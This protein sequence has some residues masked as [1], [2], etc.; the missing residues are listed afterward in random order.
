MRWKEEGRIGHRKESNEGFVNMSRNLSCVYRFTLGSHII[1]KY[2]PT[3]EAP[4]TRSSYGWRRGISLRQ[5]NIHPVISLFIFHL[6]FSLFPLSLCVHFLLF[7]TCINKT[8]HTYEDNC[9]AECFASCNVDTVITSLK[10]RS[11]IPFRQPCAFHQQGRS[12]IEFNERRYAYVS[13]LRV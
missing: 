7:V 9:H 11:V 6:P 13:R 12:S 10:K 8:W 2:P 5:A 1:E 4:C 3:I